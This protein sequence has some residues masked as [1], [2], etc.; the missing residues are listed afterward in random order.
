M[1]PETP[2]V[3]TQAELDTLLTSILAAEGQRRREQQAATA[4]LYD[5]RQATRLSPDQMR[6]LHGQL[7]A[8]AA[9]LSRT[10]SLYLG[11]SARFG[12]HSIDL[13]SG[14]Q[15]VRNLAEHPVLGVVS[16]GPGNPRALW[17]LSPGVAWTALDCML[18][19]PATRAA[20]PGRELTALSAAVLQR[21]FAEILSAWTELWAPLKALGP[22]VEEVVASPRTVDTRAGD[23][24]LFFV[25]MEAA[26]G[27]AQGLLRL[28][29]PLSLMRRLVRE[30]KENAAPALPPALALEPS[31]RGALAETPVLLKAQIE[32]P[33]VSLR[34]LMN[35]QPGEVLDLRLPADTLFHV[36][37]SA[38]PK[39]RAQAGV[40]AGRVAVR[41]VDDLG[42]E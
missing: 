37:V 29:V 18:G 41:L 28:A 33:P 12:V 27:Q 36:E 3:I 24:R 14:E 34:E 30:E 19:G 11:A 23:D 39:F 20:E 5:F 21:L 15:Y 7:V 26:V 38:V 10:L 8:L 40:S 13:A 25:I 16:F 31:A 4:S 6:A 35:L 1:N 9:I 32:P 42:A 2:E 17:E 22:Q